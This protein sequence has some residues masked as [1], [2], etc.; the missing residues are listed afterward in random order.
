MLVPFSRNA[1]SKLCASGLTLRGLQADAHSALQFLARETP[2]FTTLSD[3]H[4]NVT[5]KKYNSKLQVVEIS[6][7][8]CSFSSVKDC[9]LSTPSSDIQTS[10]GSEQV[11]CYKHIKYHPQNERLYFKKLNSHAYFEHTGQIQ[12]NKS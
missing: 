9:N 7:I 11:R 6:Y 2:V 1:V 3:S 8:T 10:A 5:R 4:K 12:Q